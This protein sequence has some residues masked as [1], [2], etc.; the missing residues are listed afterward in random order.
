M[1]DECTGRRLVVSFRGG[2]SEN[3]FVRFILLFCGPFRVR[4]TNR[5]ACNYVV[6]SCHQLC[7]KSLQP[8]HSLVVGGIRVWQHAA[9]FHVFSH[10]SL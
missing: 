9:H 2:P 4:M 7:V 3:I 6:S 1:L 8:C 5:C 10:K